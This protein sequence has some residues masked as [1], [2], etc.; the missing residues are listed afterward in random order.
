MS[1]IINIRLYVILCHDVSLENIKKGLFIQFY[2]F[3]QD[4]VF[5][6]MS[7]TM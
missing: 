6:I 7:T 4:F 3:K 1:Y 2:F 5:T